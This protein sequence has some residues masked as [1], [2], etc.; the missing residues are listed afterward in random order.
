[1]KRNL[2]TD[3][4][5]IC[6]TILL[7]TTAASFAQTHAY[8][9]D[10]TNGLRDLGTLGGDS[11][12]YAI[13]DSGAVVGTYIPLDKFYYHGFIWTEATGMVDLGIPGGGHSRTKPASQPPST[14][15][16]MS[17]A[18]GGRQMANR[19]HSIGPQRTGLPS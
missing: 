14:R 7:A 18:T 3:F 10:A 4:Y 8:T 13:N 16:E 1:M 15:R 19:L 11:F 2:I 9:W 5:S 17:S 12:A 6:A